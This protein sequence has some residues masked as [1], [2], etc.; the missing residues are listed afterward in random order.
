MARSTRP[1]WARPADDGQFDGTFA[2][3]FGDGLQEGHQ[4]LHG[5]VTRGRDHDPPR[6]RRDV[7][8]R[9][10]DGVIH[11]DRHDGHALGTHQHL[12]GDVPPGR[13]GDRHHRR[14]GA[15][16]AQLHAQKAVPATGR[17]ALPGI[18]GVGQ[19]QLAVHGDRMVQGGQQVP[20]VVDHAQHPGAQALVVVDHVEV[21]EPTRQQRPRPLGEGQRLPEAGGAHDAELDPVLEAGELPRVGHTEGVGLPVEIEPGDRRESDPG[22]ELGP[23]RTGEHLDRVPQGDEL[24]GQVAGVDPLATAAGVAAIEEEGDPQTAR[25]WRCGRNRGRN[26]NVPRALPGLLDRDPLLAGRFRQGVSRH[27]RPWP[28]SLPEPPAPAQ[29]MAPDGAPGDLSRS[30]TSPER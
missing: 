6:C 14:Q 3:E 26:L 23:G 19:I 13:V 20:A 7:V 29:T 18:R 9:A 25:S 27:V 28:H 2:A 11:A 30:R 12:R 10:E 24:A 5:D 21:A 22:V 16:H 15:R 4:T 1:P 8:P 17:H